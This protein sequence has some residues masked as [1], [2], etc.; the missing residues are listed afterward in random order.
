MSSSNPDVAHARLETF[1]AAVRVRG[2]QRATYLAAHPELY[3]DQHFA[4][5][6]AE[7]TDDEREV[8]SDLIAGISDEIAARRAR[9]SDVVLGHGPYELLHVQVGDGVLTQHAGERAAAARWH[10]A[11]ADTYLRA[12]GTFAGRLQPAHALRLLRIVRA[13]TAARPGGPAADDAGLQIEL[14]FTSAAGQYLLDVADGRVYRE[15]VAAAELALA[16]GSTRGDAGLQSDALIALGALCTNPYTGRRSSKN[17]QIE[18]DQWQRRFWAN[19]RDELVGLAP[20]EWAMPPV[21]EALVRGAEYYRRATELLDGHDLGLALKAAFQSLAIAETLGEPVDRT[22]LVALG[23]RA[24]SLIDPVQAPGELTTLLSN[25]N[26]LGDDVDLAVLDSLLAPSHDRILT[27]HGMQVAL[28]RVHGAVNLLGQS[29]PQ[30]AAEVVRSARALVELLDEAWAR[31]RQWSTEIESAVRALVPGGY[32]ALPDGPADHAAA[33]VLQRAEDEGWDP[34]AR[35]A[36]LTG[37]AA[38][39]GRTDDEAVGL[40][41][42]EMASDIAPV[43]ALDHRQ[44]LSFLQGNLHL[45]LGVNAVN[46]EDWP[47]AVEQYGVA[48]AVMI[49]LQLSDAALDVLGRIDDLVA[50][51]GHDGAVNAIIGIMPH[52]LVLENLAGAAATF[53]LQQVCRNAVAAMVGDSGQSVNPEAVLAVLQVA[54]GMRYA[55]LLLAGRRFR[56]AEDSHGARLLAQLEELEAHDIADGGIPDMD[57]PVD[58]NILLAAHAIAVG[59]ESDPSDTVGQAAALRRAYDRHLSALLFS[60]DAT[61]DLVVLSSEAIR[62]ALDRHTALVNLYIGAAQDGSVALYTVAITRDDIRAA[63]TSLGFPWSEV[64]LEDDEHS[65][66]TTVVGVMISNLRRSLLEPSEPDDVSEE[67]AEGLDTL[68]SGLM[69]GVASWLDDWRA[70]GIDHLC[71]VP[72]GPLHVAPL[73]LL[74]HEGRPLAQDWIVTVLP[75]LALLLDERG[76]ATTGTRR[77]VALSSFGLAYHGGRPHGLTPLVH[78]TH[79]AEVVARVFGAQAFIDDEATE[80]RFREALQT[81]RFLHVAAH[82]RYDVNAPA[83]HCLYLTPDDARE[84][85]ETTDG[86]VRAHELATLDVRG[87]ELVTLSACETSLGGVDGADNVAGLPAALFASGVRTIVG[88]LWDVRSDAA[89]YFFETLYTRLRDGARRHHAFT[90]AQRLTRERFPAYRDWGAFCYLG[91]WD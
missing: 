32:D 23:R 48:L 33:A 45:G 83:F 84:S 18:L 54:K 65:A 41:L 20:E 25:L 63:A 79:E 71:F 13:G 73:H 14:R 56:A 34:A 43:W 7:A 27:E 51:A 2:E 81:S 4:D 64:Q 12:L 24:V 55:G 90:Q 75:N 60:G 59:A 28:D 78:A 62:R 87:T 57:K 89:A 85:A 91:N 8:L 86:R 82:G 35:A 3:A 58:E 39:S 50:R 52:A 76:G 68:L 29:A 42:L 16:A 69:P 26:V 6:L 15:A 72:H 40:E 80:L 66:R 70:A 44:V 36:A 21:G 37:L 30:R 11:E 61:Q 67:A 46:I 49:E 9:R 38:M 53:Y 47:V 17:L 74:H 1:R 10:A 19:H 88:T 22:E 31:S 77:D 5:V